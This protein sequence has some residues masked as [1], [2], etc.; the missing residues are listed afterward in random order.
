MAA[1][2]TPPSHSRNGPTRAGPF[3]T[4]AQLDECAEEL[5]ADH[6]TASNM[7]RGWDDRRRFPA[8]GDS[9]T[10]TRDGRPTEIGN[11][12]ILFN[13]KVEALTPE[14]FAGRGFTE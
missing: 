1:T 5:W 10:P 7:I 3:T 2:S 9:T 6:H 12:L 8:P 11:I 13:G 4:Q 14:E